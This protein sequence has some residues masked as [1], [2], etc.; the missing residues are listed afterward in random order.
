MQSYRCPIDGRVTAIDIDKTSKY[1]A[2]GSSKGDV[3]VINMQSGG[4]IYQL[5]SH[6]D[7]KHP[8]AKKEITI[9]KFN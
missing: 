3:V 4:V 2:V 6:P 8:N 7:K 5:T 1:L 9:L